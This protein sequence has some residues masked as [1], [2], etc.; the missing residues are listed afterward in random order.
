MRLYIILS[1]LYLLINTSGVV[2]ETISLFSVEINLDLSY[3]ATTSFEKLVEHISNS[4]N[5]HH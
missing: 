4:K 3:S 2:L 1:K 5:E